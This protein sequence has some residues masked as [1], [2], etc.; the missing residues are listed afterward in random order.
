MPLPLVPR[1]A[2]LETVPQA[3]LTW[4]GAVVKDQESEFASMYAAEFTAVSRT[5][6]L[7]LHD[8]Q[9]AEDITQDA[10]IQLYSH[11]GRVSR[12]ERPGAWVRRVAIRLALRHQNRERI[13]AVLERN[14]EPPAVPQ[15]AD[16]DLLRS[17]RQLPPAY[18]AALVLHYYE[19]WPVA[20]VASVLGWTVSATKVKLMRARR[21]LGGLLQE[22]VAEDVS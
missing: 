15:P 22:E 17:M 1:P 8:R 14:A 21:R 16:V 9:R 7:I 6:F 19:D 10:F 13:R 5:V 4:R 2:T 12:Y 3:P 11:W 20:E 18:R